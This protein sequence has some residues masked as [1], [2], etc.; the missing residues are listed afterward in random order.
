MP[1]AE[2]TSSAGSGDPVS[3][4]PFGA[5]SKMEAERVPFLHTSKSQLEV[6]ACLALPGSDRG[7]P[8]GVGTVLEAEA[9]Q[10][11][12][13]QD[14]GGTLSTVVPEPGLPSLSCPS[15]SWHCS[16]PL[17]AFPSP[18]CSEGEGLCGML[19]VL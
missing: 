16:Q 18:P 12:V 17:Q 2:P 1:G 14:P 7:G 11:R 3:P 15:L 9:L 19:L 5:E 13:H 8:W 6:K 4:W 10:S